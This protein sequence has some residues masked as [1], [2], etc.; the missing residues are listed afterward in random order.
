MRKYANLMETVGLSIIT[1]PTF[2]KQ[3]LQAK[4]VCCAGR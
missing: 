2:G 1:G 3:N 4:E